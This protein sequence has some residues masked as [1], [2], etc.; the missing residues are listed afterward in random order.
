M[1]AFVNF[2]EILWY[3]VTKPVWNYYEPKLRWE[4]ELSW[5]FC[6]EWKFHCEVDLTTWESKVSCNLTFRYT[7]SFKNVFAI[8]APPP[9]PK[10]KK[11]RKKF[12]I[13]KLI[14]HVSAVRKKA[15]QT[16]G[17]L[18]STCCVTLPSLVYITIHIRTGSLWSFTFAIHAIHEHCEG[19]CK[20]ST[21]VFL[22]LT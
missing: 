11:E 3:S 1:F 15:E 19:L 7:R 17:K 22:F 20:A 4:L 6:Y 13:R 12:C 5:S 14:S 21:I 10:K 16:Q 9:P 2:K 8:I 18:G